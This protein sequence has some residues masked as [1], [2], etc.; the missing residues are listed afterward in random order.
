MKKP[1]PIDTDI[2]DVSKVLHLGEINIQKCLFDMDLET[3]SKLKDTYDK[4]LTNGNADQHIRDYV[5]FFM[6]FKALQVYD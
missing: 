1:E 3:L 6:D 4:N 5:G 2:V